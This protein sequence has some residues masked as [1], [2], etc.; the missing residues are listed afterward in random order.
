MVLTI[1]IWREKKPKQQSK[2]CS[3]LHPSQYYAYKSW[4]TG[5]NWCQLTIILLHNNTYSGGLHR[6][7]LVSSK[8]RR[9]ICLCLTCWIANSIPIL[10]SHK[11]LNLS[12]QMVMQFNDS[13]LGCE[14]GSIKQKEMES[15]VQKFSALTKDEVA[16]ALL[17]KDSDIFHLLSQKVPCVGCRRR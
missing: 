2:I 1:H 10:I 8:I 4:S 7:V 15:F 17:V 13:C 6:I 14:K 12:F 5:P 9:M 11:I 16:I 3:R